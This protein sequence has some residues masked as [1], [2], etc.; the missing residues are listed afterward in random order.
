MIGET[1][2]EEQEMGAMTSM[3]SKGGKS[4]LRR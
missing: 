1:P 2:L 3:D 4:A